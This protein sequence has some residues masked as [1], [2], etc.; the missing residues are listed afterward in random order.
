[1]NTGMFIREHLLKV[2]E[3][4]PFRMYRLLKNVKK[5]LGLKMGSYQNFRNYIYWLRKLGLIEFVREEPSDNPVLVHPR[6]YYKLT[7]KGRERPGLF[8]NP[9]RALYPRSYIK[10]HKIPW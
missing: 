5:G 4:Y 10:S 9:R 3:D 7:K 1:M 8:L 6:R 2:G